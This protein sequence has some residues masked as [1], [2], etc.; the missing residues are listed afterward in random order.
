MHLQPGKFEQPQNL[1]P[2][3][4]LVLKTI[5]FSHFGQNFRSS[6]N[7]LEISSE[8]MGADSS[9]ILINSVSLNIRIPYLSANDFA[10]PEYPTNVI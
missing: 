6:E 5:S 10:S 3:R 8:P 4:R 7:S 1:F 9:N 2:F